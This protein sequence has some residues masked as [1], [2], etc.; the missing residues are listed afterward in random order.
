MTRTGYW[1]LGALLVAIAL[2]A[3]RPGDQTQEISEI[4]PGTS[5]VLERDAEGQPLLARVA[6]VHALPRWVESR[7]A[8]GGTWSYLLRDGN[9]VVVFDVGP[10]YPLA[11]CLLSWSAPKAFVR[12]LDN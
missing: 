2:A 9:G 4:A 7:M 8:L 5:E 10:R 11:W 3:L 12:R 6:L 1:L